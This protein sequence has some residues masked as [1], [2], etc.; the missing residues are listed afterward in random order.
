MSKIVIGRSNVK[1]RHFWNKPT[2]TEKLVEIAPHLDIHII[3]DNSVNLN[4]R[5]KPHS[6]FY[7]FIPYPKDI[8]ITFVILALT[9]LLG[10]AFYK[11]G[12]TDSNI[13]TVYILG[14]LLTSLFTRGYAC[15][16]IGSSHIAYTAE[17]IAEV[18]GMD[19]QELIDRCNEN[20]RMLFGI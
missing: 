19:T 17:K 9:T 1:R 13:I 15:G 16:M 14:V 2:L 11:L 8:M 10:I 3:P 12:F 7:N 18:K 5:D 20:S 4:Y 6:F